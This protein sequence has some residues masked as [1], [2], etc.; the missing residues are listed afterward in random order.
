MVT[1][2]LVHSYWFII[3]VIAAVIA[4]VGLTF[5]SKDQ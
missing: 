2:N 1:G 3:L 4:T 5:R